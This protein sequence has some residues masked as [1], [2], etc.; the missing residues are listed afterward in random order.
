MRLRAPDP[1]TGV[2]YGEIHLPSETYNYVYQIGEVIL[3]DFEDMELFTLVRDDYL[4][5][6]TD[7]RQI[8]INMP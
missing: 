8:R 4:A 5:T 3:W 7:M 6:I 2:I 1:V